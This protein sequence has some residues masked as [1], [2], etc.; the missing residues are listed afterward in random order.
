MKTQSFSKRTMTCGDARAEHIGSTVVLNGWVH[1]RR[2]LGGLIFIDLRDRYGMT[3]VV[4][5]PQ[6]KPELFAQAEK[7]RSEFVISVTGLVRERPEGAH[8]ANIA[9]GDVEVAV[10]ELEILNTC[11]TPPIQV[12]DNSS[13]DESLRLKFRFLDLRRSRMQENLILRHKMA[14][15]TRD[16]LDKEGFLEIETPML[17]SATP[18]GARDFLVPSRLSPGKF[19]ALPQSPQIFKQILMVSGF[20]KYFQIARCFR[21]EDLRADRQ[22]EFTQIDMEMSFVSRDDVLGVSERLMQY[23]F[24]T[25]MNIDIPVPFHRMSWEESMNRFGNDKPDTRFGMEIIDVTEH[26]K[27]TEFQA[28][29]DAIGSGGAVRGIVLPGCAGY[30]RKQ[31]DELTEFAKKAGAKG[32]LSAALKEDGEFKSVLSKY[33]SPEQIAEL[34]TA[35]GAKDGDLL[36]I[37]AGEA[38]FISAILGKLRLEMGKRLNLIDKGKF[39]FLYVV[40]F[41]MYKYNEEEKR[42]E[43]EHHPFTSPKPEDMHLLETEPLKVKADAYDMVLNGNEVASGS[44]RI[45]SRDLQKRVF[46]AIGISDEEAE[47]KFGFLLN[48]FEYGAPPHGGIAPGLDRIAAIAAGEETIRDVIAFP[49]NT[50]GDCLMTGA[51]IAVESDQLKILKLKVEG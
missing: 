28:F 35:F 23:V 31:L 19:Y 41:P 15:A 27:N 8:N 30:S 17:V 24:K 2:D 44:I 22:P 36:A 1:R 6:E 45:H 9:T 7:L 14:K 40:D 42:L 38:M 21:D 12:A 47:E 5:N 46:N 18:E 49:K 25:V 10:N 34:K 39:N 50:G 32:I 16:F 37:M 48:T 13:V 4:F 29:N 51:P 20:D 43:T 3:Q 26:V 33:L 11:K